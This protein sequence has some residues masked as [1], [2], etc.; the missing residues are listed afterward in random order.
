M[1]DAGLL[2]VVGLALVWAVVSWAVARAWWEV[3]E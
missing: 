1:T 3:Y 2:L